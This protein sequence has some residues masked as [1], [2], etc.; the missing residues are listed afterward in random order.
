[1]GSCPPSCLGK[2]IILCCPGRRRGG[3]LYKRRSGYTYFLCLFS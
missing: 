1:M 3:F 2:Y